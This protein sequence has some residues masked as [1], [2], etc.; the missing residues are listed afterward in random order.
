M[1]GFIIDQYYHEWSDGLSE[2]DALV[3]IFTNIRDMPNIIL[4]GVWDTVS[5]ATHG[6]AGLLL[7]AAYHPL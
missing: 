1:T 4:P 6:W 2:Q 3:S 7:F 5:R